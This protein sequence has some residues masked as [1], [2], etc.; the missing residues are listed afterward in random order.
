MDA[1]DRIADSRKDPEWFRQKLVQDQS[2]FPRE[3]IRWTPEED[4][5]LRKLYKENKLTYKEIG[6]R[7][8]RSAGAVNNR[9][10]RII[11]WDEQ[12]SLKKAK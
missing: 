9:L 4:A 6:E 5:L 11:I 8:G 2:R 7:L 12:S 3:F 1:S 10:A